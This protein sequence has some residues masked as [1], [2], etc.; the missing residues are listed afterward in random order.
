MFL[1]TT[2]YFLISE[3]SHST[4]IL[5]NPR[6]NRFEISHIVLQ[7]L[8]LDMKAKY[9]KAATDLDLQAVNNDD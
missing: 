1:G 8:Y 6:T 4:I 5:L 7:I 2:F 9:S 3:R